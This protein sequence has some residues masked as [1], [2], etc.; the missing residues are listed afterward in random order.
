MIASNESL[1]R[2]CAV[3]LPGALL[4]S[5]CLLVCVVGCGGDGAKMG[6][7]DG[8]VLL[9]G[10]PLTSGKVLFQPAAGQGAEGTIQPDGT[11]TMVTEG[12]GDGVVVGE[13]Q[14]AIVAYAKGSG[15]RHVPGGPRT[16]AKPLVPERYLAPG[17]SGLKCD[18][19][20]G[21]NH[22]EFKLTSP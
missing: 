6:N 12:E 3:G 20:P 9:D 7:V 5:S 10:Q 21:D 8:V 18:V 19:K 1:R 2:Q 4:L 16:T 22:P 17:T 13:H 11:F 14:V 15:G